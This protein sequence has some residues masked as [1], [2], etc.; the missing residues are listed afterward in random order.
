MAHSRLLVLGE[1]VEALM[2]P[3]W[4]GNL[5]AVSP[6][7]DYWGVG[8]GFSGQLL[9]LPGVYPRDE[10]GCADSA[11]VRDVDIEGMRR[12]AVA[13]AEKTWRIYAE[14]LAEHGEPKTRQE[15]AED[16]GAKG[17]D[18]AYIG[19]PLIQAV[20]PVLPWGEELTDFF[21][22]GHAAFIE[23]ARLAAVPGRA[24]LTERDGW[25]EA[26]RV[27]L[28]GFVYG[29]IAQREQFLAHA[30]EVLDAATGY[31]LLTIVDYHM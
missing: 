30:N 16:V 3:F 12:R 23:R 4:E 22:G 2:G 10:D 17:A 15:C 13:R 25:L 21:Y 1:D 20:L 26:S 27:D 18:Q 29:S 11:H 19:Q 8:E 14:A 28:W 31:E 5:D 7:W 9:M 6:R 24:M